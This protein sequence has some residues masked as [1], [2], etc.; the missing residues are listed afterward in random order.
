MTS[1]RRLA[2]LTVVGAAALAL[3]RSS[4]SPDAP[5][6]AAALARV[7]A[8][9]S[10]VAS[11][12]Q[13][14]QEA[15]SEADDPRSPIYSRTILRSRAHAQERILGRDQGTED[16]A[17]RIVPARRV[18]L[19][20]GQ[21]PAPVNGNSLGSFVA[22]ENEA[23]LARFHAAL[24]TLSTH[25]KQKNKVRIAV[26]GA[27]HTQADIYSSY[28]RYYLQERFG[29]GG[30]GFV[31]LGM[32]RGWSQHDFPVTSQGLLVEYVQNKGTPP[33]GRYGL[34]GSA[35][36]A[37]AS[38][39]VRVE[40]RDGNEPELAASQYRLFYAAEPEGGEIS[41]SV[42]GE[43]PLLLSTRSEQ[44]EPRSQFFERP[45][46]WHAVEV[47]ALGEGSSRLFGISIERRQPGLVID[48]L[49]IRGTRAATLLFWDQ[50]LWEQPL[51]QRAPDL[52]ILAYGT[53]ETTDQRQPIQEYASS[54]ALVLQRVRHTL[55]QAS[56]L[57]VGPGD[58]PKAQGDG[59]VT[60]PRLLE[61]IAEQRRLAP[62]FGCGFWDAYSFMGGA[63]SMAEWARSNPRLGATD[64][65]H[66][67]TRG[68]VR[69]G[70]ALGDAMMRAYD[71]RHVPRP[72]RV[73]V[74]RESEGPDSG[75]R[76]AAGA[77]SDSL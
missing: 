65:I 27:S 29:N 13:P 25:P 9:G 54:L 1:L 75:V 73:A 12:A 44:V 39:W 8:H 14:S 20:E 67:T 35:A 5:T 72:L 26:Y 77:G 43:E 24:D 50:Q 48:T 53:N 57:L 42:D 7:A 28:L 23:A 21:L 55:S 47:Q 68:Y 56:C 17:G 66:L 74:Q 70:M 62:Q 38:A 49:G 32:E 36:V 76:A 64:H 71:A 10:E 46:G 41:L 52:V 31:P 58:F 63:G 4:A 30:P 11:E 16:A 61:I 18:A 22:V 51:R 40:P 37:K 3:T 60:R 6:H 69:M 45:L 15:A 34:S 2:G 59:W 19:D 33:H